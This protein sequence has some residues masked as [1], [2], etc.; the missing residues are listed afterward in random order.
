MEITLS[1]WRLILLAALFTEF[2]IYLA[3]MVVVFFHRRGEIIS[4]SLK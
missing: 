3:A 1:L 2:G 4:N